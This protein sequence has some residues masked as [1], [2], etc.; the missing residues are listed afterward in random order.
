[1][2]GDGAYRL[3]EFKLVYRECSF[4]RD[5]GED[6]QDAICSGRNARGG[7][8]WVRISVTLR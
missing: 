4:T 2:V 5:N 1:M 6:S 8:G 3:A 7:G